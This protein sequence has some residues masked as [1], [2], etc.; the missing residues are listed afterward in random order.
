MHVD[1]SAWP[2]DILGSVQVDGAGGIVGET[3]E[4]AWSGTYRII[5]REG[6]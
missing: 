5:T 1:D 6:M 4:F 2:E 3:G